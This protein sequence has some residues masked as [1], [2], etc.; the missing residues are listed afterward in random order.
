MRFPPQREIGLGWTDLVCVK[1]EK[2]DSFLAAIQ[3]V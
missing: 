1:R 2:V 3:F